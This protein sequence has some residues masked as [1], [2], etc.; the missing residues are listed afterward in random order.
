MLF[1]ETKINVY[2]S[3]HLFWNAW[4][5]LLKLK[6]GLWHRY[7]VVYNT[8]MSD[9]PAV[10]HRSALIISTMIENTYCIYMHMYRTYLTSQRPIIQAW[11][12]TITRSK[13]FIHVYML[14][15]TYSFSF[16]LFFS[17]KCLALIQTYTWVALVIYISSQVSYMQIYLVNYN[18][19]SKVESFR[20]ISIDT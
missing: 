16:C 19:L 10:P 9:Y 1:K 6:S 14:P 17:L 20:K 18:Y 11:N 2:K 13:A 3:L 8:S 7:H 12:S 15:Y 4:M 5:Q